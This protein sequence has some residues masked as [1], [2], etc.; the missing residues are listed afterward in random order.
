I[1]GYT[2][3]EKLNIALR[4]LI[5]K[6]LTANGLKEQEIDIK[7]E[8]IRDIVRY[9]T[10]EAGVIGLE[11]E[12]AKLC[13]KVVTRHVKNKSTASDVVDSAS[14]EDRLGVRK[15]DSGRAENKD[16]VGKVTGPAWTQVGREL[17]AIA[18]SEVG[19]KGRM[20]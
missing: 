10:R 12:I 7:P 14:L 16:Q 6:Q 17:L 1:P 20:I 8:A 3:D 13:R 18:S 2:E 15:L 9:Y 4:Y 5:P 11:R 19:G